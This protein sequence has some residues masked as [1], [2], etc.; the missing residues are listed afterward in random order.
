M[1]EVLRRTREL[2]PS[3]AGVHVADVA[4]ERV[5][6]ADPAAAIAVG[7]IR[8]RGGDRAADD[9]GADQAE[10]PARMNAV[11]WQMKQSR[12]RILGSKGRVG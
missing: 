3:V 9:G 10:A 11:G 6:L 5:V 1:D 2:S 7:R 8:G 4:A 12:S